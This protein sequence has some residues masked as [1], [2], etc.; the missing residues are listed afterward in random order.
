M[1]LSRKGK[2]KEGHNKMQDRVDRIAKRKQ[3]NAAT[4]WNIKGQEKMSKR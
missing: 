1:P 4:S 2:R 3:N